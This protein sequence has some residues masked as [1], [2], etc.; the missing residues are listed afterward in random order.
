MA[1][2]RGLRLCA[3]AALLTILLACG[4]GSKGL[5]KGSGPRTSS[6]G[7]SLR[8]PDGWATKQMSE[9]G[10]LVIAERPADLDASA[11]SAARLTARPAAA[12]SPP[13]DNAISNIDTT[14]LIGR[15]TTSETTVGGKRAGVIEWTS[16]IDGHEVTTRLITVP[17]GGGRAYTLTFEAP[18]DDFGDVNSKLDSMLDSVEF[19]VSSVPPAK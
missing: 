17:L 3:V 15:A 6:A 12:V 19:D 8:A 18:S 13:G 9:P 1:S 11:P 5:L 14:P 7:V 2:G 16:T 10:G 4:G